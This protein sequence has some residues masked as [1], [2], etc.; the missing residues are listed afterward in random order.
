MHES[1]VRCHND[2]RKRREISRLRRRWT[3]L[4]WSGWL[5]VGEDLVN[6]KNN[7]GEKKRALDRIPTAAANSP[8]T[9]DHSTRDGHPN[10]GRIDIG[11][12]GELKDAP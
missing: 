7:I 5:I 4:N 11:Y 1:G 9:Q 2:G 12:L 10:Q 3:R 8:G 6:A